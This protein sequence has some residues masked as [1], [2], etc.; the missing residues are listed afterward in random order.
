MAIDLHVFSVTYELTIHKWMSSLSEESMEQLGLDKSLVW[1]LRCSSK[2][3]KI[4]TEVIIQGKDISHVVVANKL[5][6]LNE[7]FWRNAQSRAKGYDYAVK[8]REIR[9][10]TLRELVKDSHCLAPILE[11]QK[12]KQDAEDWYDV[13]A[14]YG[15]PSN[16]AK[17]P[18][19]KLVDP[20]EPPEP[21]IDPPSCSN[22]GSLM[23]PDDTTCWECDY[24]PYV[25]F[26]YI[27]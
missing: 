22:C 24:D 3:Q 13:M 6:E 27:S 16:S 12:T 15:E 26:G 2:P 8:I 10:K 1:D 18:F 21:E 5:N 20:E 25:G 14:P 23:S 4:T 9:E 17:E 7:P 11:E 19:R